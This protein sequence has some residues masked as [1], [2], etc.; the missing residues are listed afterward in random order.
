MLM[1]NLVEQNVRQILSGSSKIY[2]LHFGRM[3][4]IK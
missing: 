1:E 4:W 2:F 3:Y